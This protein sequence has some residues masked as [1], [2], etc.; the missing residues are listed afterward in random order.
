MVMAGEQAEAEGFGRA[1][2]Q[3]VV[4]FYA[5]GVLLA[6]PWP[7][8]LQESLDVLTGI[9]GQIGLWTNVGET[10]GMTCQPCRMSG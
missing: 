2:H 5:Y 9:F 1:V 10:V 7:E 8:Y 3:L 6:P 4:L